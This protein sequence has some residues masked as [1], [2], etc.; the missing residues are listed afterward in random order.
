[1]RLLQCLSLIILLLSASFVFAEGRG[2]ACFAFNLKSQKW[3][4]PGY[5]FGPNCYRPVTQSEAQAERCRG[6][7]MRKGPSG[8]TCQVIGSFFDFAAPRPDQPALVLGELNYQDGSWRDYFIGSGET[9]EKAREQFETNCRVNGF[10]CVLR[11][12]GGGLPGWFA[13]AMSRSTSS[14]QLPTVVLHGERGT[15]T[16]VEAWRAAK[17]RCEAETSSECFVTLVFWKEKGEE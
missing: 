6:V 13:I 3:D 17:H 7:A 14:E 2:E 12:T 10:Q 5:K 4:L 11:G 9:I 16:S 1:M 15:A 8:K